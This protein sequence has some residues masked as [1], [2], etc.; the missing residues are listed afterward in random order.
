[1]RFI[2]YNQQL[3]D[4]TEANPMLDWQGHLYL[5]VTYF[6]LNP[7]FTLN[8]F[9]ISSSHLSFKCL[10]H[11]THQGRKEIEKEGVI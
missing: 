9:M 5:W 2:F 3:S 10:N 4:L 6:R 11:S 1:M 8:C 7:C